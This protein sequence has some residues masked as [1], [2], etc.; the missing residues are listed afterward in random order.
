MIAWLKELGSFAT[1][2]FVF[3]L[4]AWSLLYVFRYMDDPPQ[5]TAD[6]KVVLDK[7]GNAKSILLV[8]LPLATTSV[9]YWFG[10]KGVADA[11]GVA[12]KAVREKEVILAVGPKTLLAEAQAAHPEAFGL[13]PKDGKNP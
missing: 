4:V 9:G 8:L 11:N 10:N 12:D 1:T 7:F 5:I 2:L 3:A 13:P 6:G